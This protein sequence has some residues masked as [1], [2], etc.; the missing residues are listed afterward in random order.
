MYPRLPSSSSSSHPSQSSHLAPQIPS[1]VHYV[2]S[3]TQLANTSTVTSIWSYFIEEIFDCVGDIVDTKG[4][5]GFQ[6]RTHNM[7]WNSSFA[8]ITVTTPEEITK[9]HTVVILASILALILALVWW[10]RRTDGLLIDDSQCYPAS[11]FSL[12]KGGESSSLVRTRRR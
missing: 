5:H 8:T 1:T 3:Q 12:R 9:T 10:A 7:I 4:L 11:K 6:P 2:S